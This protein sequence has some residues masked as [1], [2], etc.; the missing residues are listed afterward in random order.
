MCAT[1]WK[2]VVLIVTPRNTYGITPNDV[3][4][5]LGALSERG[6]AIGMPTAASS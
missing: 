6:V 4:G 3:D 5:F 2:D 1:S